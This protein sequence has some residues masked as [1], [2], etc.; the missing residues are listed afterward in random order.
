MKNLLVVTILVAGTFA[1]VSTASA[2]ENLN[3]GT[4]NWVLETFATGIR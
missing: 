4:S 3:T 1:S 2:I